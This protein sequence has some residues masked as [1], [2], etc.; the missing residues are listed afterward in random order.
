MWNSDNFTRRG[1]RLW[2]IP[3]VLLATSYSPA[4]ANVSLGSN[5]VPTTKLHQ[6]TVS[7]TVRDAGNNQPL[8]GVTISIKGT[9]TATQTDASGNFSIQASNGQVIVANYI[10]FKSQEKTVSSSS[11][12][13]SLES[14]DQQI[15]ELVVVGYGTMRKSDVTGS[16]SNVKGE[17]MIKAQS[18]SPLENLRGKAPGVNIYSNSSQ[19]GAYANRVIIRGTNTINSSSNPLYVVDGVVMQDF[20]LLNPND[21]ESI[22]VLKDAS[23]AAIYGA[24]GANGVILVT[25]KRG[26]KDGRKTISYQGSVSSNSVQR[27]MDVLTGQEW[28]DAFMIGLQNENNWQGK[29]WNLDKK[30][31]FNDPNYFDASGNPLYNTDWQK[32]ATRNSLSH[33]HQI[34]IQQGDESSSVGAFLNYSENQGVVNN[35]YSKRINAKLAYDSKVKEWLSTSVNLLA[36]HTWGRHTPEDGGGQDARRTMIEMLPWLPIYQPDGK[37]TSSSSSTVSNVLAFEGMANPVSI[38]DLQKRMRYNTQ[39]FGNAALTFH[40]ADGLDLKTQFGIDNHRKEYRGYSSITLNNISRPNGWAEV[41]SW[42][43]LYWQE[44]T[45]L[46]YNKTFDKHRVNA[47]AGLSWQERT[48]YGFNVRTEGFTTD[49]Y[50]Y[51][52]LGVGSIPGSPGS[53][54]NKWAMNSYF[55]RGNYSYDDRYS[56]TLTARADGSSKFGENNKYGFFPS[57]GVAWNIGNE[58][59][60]KD[61]TTVSNL[62]LHTSYGVTGNSEINPYSSLFMINAGTSLMNGVREPFGFV[63]NLGNPDLRWE[64]TKTYDA[65]FE[66]GLFQ[67]RLNFD[68]SV[69]NRTTTDLLLEA[70]VPYATGY[71]SVY[72]NIGSVRNRG[73]EILVNASPVRTD[74]LSWNITLNGSYNKNEVLKLGENNEDILLNGW[75]G[76]PNSI[77]RV[78]ENLNSFYGYKRNGIYTVQDFENGDIEENKIGRPNRSTNQQILG[79]GVPDWMGSFINTV[80]YKNF[81]LTVDLQFVYGVETMQQFFHSTYDRFGIT[82]GLKTILTDAYNGTNPNTM[83]QAIYLQNN[84]HAGQDTNVD[85]QWVV[86]GS[87]LRVNVLQLGYTFKSDLASR[88]GFSALRIYA[89]ANNP[90]LITS[91]KF[92]GYDP[93]STSLG[94]GNKFGQNMTFFSYPRAKTFTFGVNLTL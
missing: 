27:Y 57:A 52:N 5:T 19:P 92:Q 79:K 37:Y 10:G 80:N 14:T 45:Y 9:T 77:I 39:I 71:A 66:L 86:D 30:S 56:V 38:L 29:N 16:I 88:M 72:K 21:I 23:S 69:Y 46:T 90:W 3:L 54:T 84:G 44:E 89:S 65:G 1:N 18:F 73:V 87:Y 4:N 61:Q 47:M 76:G 24:R 70:P 12:S 75:V 42:N 62:K 94:E 28:V 67:N 34:D 91:S 15:E 48:Y 93:E 53:G 2:I 82:N 40:I 85:S 25:T 17:D 68:V 6:Q 78:G 13:F 20:H 8:E 32:E 36:N 49:A 41:N 50:E 31:W 74:D 55:V 81:D 63:G 60:M 22:E 58:A 64:K 33:N 51:N 35:T 7:G 43:D 11:M 83:Q 59:F 26:N